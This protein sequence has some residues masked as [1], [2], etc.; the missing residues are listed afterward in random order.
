MTYVV[1]A[2]GD[3]GNRNLRDVVTMERSRRGIIHDSLYR[4]EKKDIIIFL[5]YI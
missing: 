4:R 5:F 1:E 2:V 3:D